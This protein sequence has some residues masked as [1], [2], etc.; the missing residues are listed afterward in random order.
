MKDHLLAL[1]ANEQNPRMRLN[2]V[3]EYVRHRVTFGKGRGR[4]F[5]IEKFVSL[6]EPT[7][8]NYSELSSPTGTD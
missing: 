8:S 7:N 5:L 4:R 1:A 6:L 3:R 2:I